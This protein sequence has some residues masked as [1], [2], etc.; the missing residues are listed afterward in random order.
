MKTIESLLESSVRATNCDY[1]KYSKNALKWNVQKGIKDLVSDINTTARS[2]TFYPTVVCEDNMYEHIYKSA[3]LW[4]ATEAVCQLKKSFKDYTGIIR[5]IPRYVRPSRA[6]WPQDNELAVWINYSNNDYINNSE[7]SDPS[8][9]ET[10]I[11]S[12]IEWQGFNRELYPYLLS[13]TED[14]VLVRFPNGM[15]RPKDIDLLMQVCG[16]EQEN[17][18]WENNFHTVSVPKG[19]GGRFTI[20]GINAQGWLGGPVYRLNTSDIEGTIEVEK[21]GKSYRLTVTEGADRVFV[22]QDMIVAGQAVTLDFPCRL[23]INNITINIT[24]NGK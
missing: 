24:R 17:V 12:H 11:Q 9:T 15:T 10:F 5:I 13:I 6:P 16:G 8:D 1:F 7:C 3:V 14:Q 23:T 4:A 18:L 19:Q 21:K 2:H 22:D 20:G